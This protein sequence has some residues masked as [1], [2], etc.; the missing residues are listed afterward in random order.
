MNTKSNDYVDSPPSMCFSYQPIRPGWENEP[1]L[2]ISSLILKHYVK[3]GHVA[4]ADGFSYQRCAHDEFSST[5]STDFVHGRNRA[6]KIG[7]LLVEK[8]L[9]R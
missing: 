7:T 3:L 4:T 9:G 5:S 1:K 6:I 8:Q 2:K